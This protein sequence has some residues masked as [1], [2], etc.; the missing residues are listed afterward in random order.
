MFGNHAARRRRSASYRVQN[1]VDE[2]MDMVRDQAKQPAMWGA[3]LSVAVCALMG[4][5][6][7]KNREE[8]SGIRVVAARAKRALRREMR[9]KI[10][11]VVR[12][13]KKAVAS[14]THA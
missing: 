4:Y 3:A 5:T 2:G 11:S 6:A 13:K 7:Y 14:K 8:P 12:G 10:R 9:S 1:W